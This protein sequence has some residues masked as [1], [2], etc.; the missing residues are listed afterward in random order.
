MYEIAL[1]K[2]NELGFIVKRN[3]CYYKIY[4]SNGNLIKNCRGVLRFYRFMY[5]QY[6][7]K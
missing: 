2:C 5:D 3:Y 7:K 4:D 1:N 6:R